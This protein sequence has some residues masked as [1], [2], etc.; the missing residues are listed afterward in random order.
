MA[1]QILL[2]RDYDNNWHEISILPESEI[3]NRMLSTPEAQGGRMERVHVL[4]PDRLGS[5]PSSVTS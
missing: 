3:D 5:H 2:P 4:E 1:S